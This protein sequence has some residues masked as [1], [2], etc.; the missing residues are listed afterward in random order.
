[1]LA[2]TGEHLVPAT[3]LQEPVV[4]VEVEALV[5]V[6][7]A[8]AAELEPV[9]V[10][11]ARPDVAPYGKRAAVVSRHH[12]HRIATGAT[13]RVSERVYRLDLD[14]RSGRPRREVFDID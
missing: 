9:D 14:D 12:V 3:D 1:M 7:P 4:T 2:V 13:A 6:H 5:G 8:L 11:F 10:R